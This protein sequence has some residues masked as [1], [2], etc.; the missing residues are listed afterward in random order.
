[1]T[2]TTQLKGNLLPESLSALSST[3]KW[4][5][6]E[7]GVLEMAKNTLFSLYL[8]LAVNRGA[9]EI[10][11]RHSALKAS[12][13]DSRYERQEFVIN[14]GRIYFFGNNQSA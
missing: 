5:I 13:S 3:H 4:S 12:C 7:V 8:M 2:P 9:V 6:I 14:C 1:M 11:N 10:L